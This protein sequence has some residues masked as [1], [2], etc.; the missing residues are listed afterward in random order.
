MWEIMNNKKI[1]F[2]D[3]NWC[4]IVF[5]SAIAISFFIASAFLKIIYPICS[6]FVFLSPFIYLVIVLGIIKIAQKDKPIAESEKT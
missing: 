1:S 6:S 4:A 2:R 5:H 3:L